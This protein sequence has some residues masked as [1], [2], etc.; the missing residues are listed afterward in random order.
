M[1]HSVTNNNDS[2]AIIQQLRQKIHELELDLEHAIAQ[3]KKIADAKSINT[4]IN[5]DEPKL[6]K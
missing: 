2:A 5:R 4:W 3:C 1:T 6:E